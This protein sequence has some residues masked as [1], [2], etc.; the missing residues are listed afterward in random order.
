MVRTTASSTSPAA[1]AIAWS[2][3]LSASRILP[4]AARAIKLTAA[5]SKAICSCSST[6]CKCAV[7]NAGGSC[8]RLNC[9]QRDNTVTGIFCGSVVAR[10]NFTCPGGSSSV[11]NIALKADLDS[12]CTSSM[13]YTL[14]RPLLGAY[15]ALSNSSRMLS[16]CVL[17]AASNSIKS[18]KRPLSISLQALHSPHGV[19]VIPVAQFSDLAKIR[20]M[21]VL[22]TP[23]V[24]VNR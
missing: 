9:R 20:A 12:I 24:P 22:P 4:C 23:R 5:D 14:K 19:A 13:I 2:N 21:V 10:M 18:M 11:F 17:D 7:I 8:F 6:Y 1:K 3:K 16:T 15:K